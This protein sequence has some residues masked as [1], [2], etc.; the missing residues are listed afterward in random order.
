MFS[1][2]TGNKALFLSRSR[3]LVAALLLGL[4]SALC[5][6]EP[7]D[8]L[9]YNL[10]YT[11]ELQP[12]K[13]RAWVVIR[14]DRSHLLRAMNFDARPEMYSNFKANGKFEIRDGRAYWELPEEDA[15]LTFYTK[16]TRERDPGRYDAR[17]T[18][19]WAIFRGDNIIPAAQT[20]EVPGAHAIATLRFQ[21]PDDWS[22]ETGWPRKRGNT[23]RIDNPER[24]YDR[25][26]GWMI[27]GKLGTRRT[28]VGN[29]SVAVSAPVGEKLR[30]MDAL[31][32]LTFVWPQVQKAFGQSPDKLLI[33]GAGD[34]MWR[35]GLSASNSLFLHADRPL[36]SE[37]GTSPLVHEIVHMVTRISG[38][39][40]K[41][42]SEDWLAE[43]IAEFY[44]FELIFRAGAMTPDRRDQ[45]IKRLKKWSADVDLLRQPRSHGPI[46]AG[47]VVLLDEL[48]KEIRSK[49]S[50]K[51]NIDDLVRLLIP[52]RKVSFEEFV[53]AAETVA[54]GKLKT[55]DT[56]LLRLPQ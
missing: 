49:T 36:V 46:T 44:S 7:D 25:P 11:V 47:A 52:I 50:D 2:A 31:T 21:L 40:S 53:K 48:D 42:H 35:G 38:E 24:L 4:F 8:D 13:N 39:K 15:R 6:A 1:L 43:G 30:R 26:V 51:A 18:D 12:E 5:Q 10:R 33:V 45:I 14:I 29:T 41:D 9:A 27:A 37:N 16:I 54:G 17:M 23:F 28:Q 20:S 34:P 19:D 55:L 22:V 56:P 3:L 32:F